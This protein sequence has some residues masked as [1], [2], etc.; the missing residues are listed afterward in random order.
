MAALGLT[1]GTIVTR[2]DD[3]QIATGHGAIAVVPIWR[4]MPDLP[5]AAE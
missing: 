5:E 3:E 4:F 1:S 2:N